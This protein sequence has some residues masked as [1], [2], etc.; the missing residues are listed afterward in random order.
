MLKGRIRCVL[1]D[2]Y[3]PSTGTRVHSFRRSY[4][5]RQKG[6]SLACREEELWLTET[7]HLSQVQTEA[8]V[9]KTRT[10]TCS[11]LGRTLRDCGK[12]RD[13]LPHTPP[14][15]RVHFL[16]SSRI[17]GQILFPLLQSRAYFEMNITNK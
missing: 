14:L 4:L 7:D 10:Q 1:M 17:L 9:E 5:S 13:F 11:T 3:D 12:I 2:C 8:H 15:Q 6:R 16:P